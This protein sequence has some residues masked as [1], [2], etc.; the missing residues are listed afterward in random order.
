MHPLNVSASLCFLSISCGRPFNTRL[1]HGVE[2]VDK[3][4]RIP[5]PGKQ[6]DSFC[7]FFYTFCLLVFCTALLQLENMIIEMFLEGKRLL[8]RVQ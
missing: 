1:N 4:D 8:R 6:Q 3:G 2:S 5:H 7:R